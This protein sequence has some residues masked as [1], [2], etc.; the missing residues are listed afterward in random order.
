MDPGLL[1]S[2]FE[3]LQPP[4]EATQVDI[5]PAPEVIAGEIRRKLVL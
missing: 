2:Q 5:T 4:A 1:H 3:A